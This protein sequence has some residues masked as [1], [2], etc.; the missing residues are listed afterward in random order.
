MFL[1]AR[2]SDIC[3][4]LG[5]SSPRILVTDSHGVP[6]LIVYGT[7]DENASYQRAVELAARIPGAKLVSIEGGDHLFAF[8]RPDEVRRAIDGFTDALADKGD[9]PLS[10]AFGYIEFSAV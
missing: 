4:P 6:T 10:L 8:T 9:E 1:A 3:L 7:R 5:V 2:N